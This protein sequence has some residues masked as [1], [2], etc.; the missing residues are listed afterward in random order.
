ML[1]LEH[2]AKGLLARCGVAIPPGVVLEDPGAPIPLA[3]PLWVKAQVPAGGRG[4]AG[5]V[6]RAETE[7]EARAHVAALLGTELL[8]HRVRRVLV[9]AATEAARECYLSLSLDRGARGPLLLASAA[10]G[11]EVERTADGLRLP[12]SPLLGVQPYARR[13]VSAHLGAPVGPVVDALWQC[14]SRFECELVE[15]NPLAV[16]A[17][18]RTVALD[19]K[20][21][22]DDRALARHPE[23][24]PR[25]EDGDLLEAAGARLAV[26][27]IRMAGDIAVAT[28][29]AGQLMATL[30]YVQALGGTLAGGLDLGGIVGHRPADLV[31]ALALL[32]EF[33]PRAFLVNSYVR[34]WK[35]DLIADAVLKAL[36]DLHP[37]RP[38][39]VRLAGHRTA[40]GE[41]ILRA[42]GIP[43]ARSLV[44][45]CRWAVDAVTARPGAERAALPRPDE[46]SADG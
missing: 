38:I 22:V 39:V 21:V 42:A 24:A 6:R 36:G 10:G 45:A 31:E 8:G 43:V 16:T 5:G 25:G 34:T 27:P 20:V 19:A 4:K 30:D 40:E 26:Y 28:T 17:D 18:G 33:A 41:A 37:G 35:N 13:R 23:V 11:V 15:V 12:V 2:E 7:A 3:P 46:R 14:F 29:G 44:E 1:L 32:R 9:E